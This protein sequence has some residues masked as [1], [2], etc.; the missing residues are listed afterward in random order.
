MKNMS[1]LGMPVQKGFTLI[2]LVIVIVILGILA[3]VALPKFVDLKRESKVAALAGV[4]GA[5]S[6]GASTNYAAKLAGNPSAITLNQSNVCTTAIL[7]SLLTGG[8]PSG[9]AINSSV[10]GNCTSTLVDSTLCWIEDSQD[11]S[12]WK[13]TPVACAR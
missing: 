1:S 7:G 10:V 4:S 6:S 8:I 5:I 3:A 9:Y 11:N 13:L 12:I 2:E